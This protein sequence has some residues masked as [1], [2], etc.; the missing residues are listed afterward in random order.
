M[1]TLNNEQN[2]VLMDGK[3]ELAKD[4]NGQNNV[5]DVTSKQQTKA[6]VKSGVFLV[7]LTA[8]CSLVAYGVYQV[9]DCISYKIEKAREKRRLKK[10][11]KKLGK[12]FCED[13]E[14]EEQ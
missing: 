8:A 11:L 12:K 13:L 1:T 2:A 6:L 4:E 5:S 10:E 7:G 9:A 14:R 3:D